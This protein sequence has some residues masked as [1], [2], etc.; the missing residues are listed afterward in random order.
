MAWD[1]GVN[2]ALGPDWEM[3]E[4]TEEAA[5]FHRV[6]PPLQRVRSV[7]GIDSRPNE[8]FATATISGIADTRNHVA[9]EVDVPA[10]G[11][12]ALLT[13][14]RPFFRGYQA[15]IGNRTLRVDSYHGLFPVVEA[16]AGAQGRLTLIYR[17]WW[18]IGGGAV[19]VF[20]AAIWLFGIFRATRA[21][22]A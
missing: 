21:R 14:S 2:P 18:L 20:C 6:G 13:F 22:V 17:P 19:A 16:P 4:S 11:P 10:G 3:V 1:S 8:S 9:A 7:A 15:S 5:V 12:P